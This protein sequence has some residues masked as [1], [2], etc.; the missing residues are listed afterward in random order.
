MFIKFIMQFQHHGD[1]MSK[2][3]QRTCD[4]GMCIK[5]IRLCVSRWY[6]NWYCKLIGEESSKCTP[7]L[8]TFYRIRMMRIILCVYQYNYRVCC[9][10]CGLVGG[11]VGTIYFTEYLHA[12]YTGDGR[13]GTAGHNRDSFSSVHHSFIGCAA[14]VQYLFSTFL[15]AVITYLL[16]WHGT[17]L[18]NLRRNWLSWDLLW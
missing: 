14:I 1:D 8:D 4:T 15:L 3:Q 2:E 7:P 6:T 13:E 5:V 18:D 11:R 12:T 10:C 16:W 9:A 17:K